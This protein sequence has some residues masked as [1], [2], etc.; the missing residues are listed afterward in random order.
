MLVSTP[1]S[2]CLALKGSRTRS[3]ARTYLAALVK[4][5]V[6]DEVDQHPAQEEAEHELPLHAAQVVDTPR[7]MQHAP[8]GRRGK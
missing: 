1:H 6:D 8:T 7:D 4:A 2:V 3:I 5:A